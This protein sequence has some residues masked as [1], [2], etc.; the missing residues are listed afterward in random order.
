MPAKS[1]II[2]V[3]FFGQFTKGADAPF[4]SMPAVG[5]SYK[6]RGFFEGRYRDKQYFTAQAEYRKIL[7][8][9]IGAAAFYSIGEVAPNF[10]SFN[11]NGIKH[12]YGFGLRFVFDPKEKI[13]L[14]VDLGIAERKTGVYFNLEEAF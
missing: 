8:W 1:H 13:N 10:S 5:G 4:F 11:M 2:A 3:Q 7:F 12:S 14:R 6:L 9:R